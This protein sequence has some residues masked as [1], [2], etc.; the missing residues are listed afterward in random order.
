MTEIDRD[1]L[2][3][4]IDLILETQKKKFSFARYRFSVKPIQN[5]DN[6]GGTSR[7]KTVKSNFS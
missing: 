6:T 4:N 7:H 3:G 2:I 5:I 1:H